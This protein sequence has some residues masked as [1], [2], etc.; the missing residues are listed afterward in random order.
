[1]KKQIIITFGDDNETDAPLY[2]MYSQQHNPQPCYLRFD[3]EA[4]VIA[5]SAQYSGEI[6]GGVPADAW[7]RTVLHFN[8]D[9]CT[10]R[11]AIEAL[12]EDEDLFDLLSEI[13]EGFSRSDSHYERGRYTPEAED[14]I[15]SV[16]IRLSERP[17]LD[18]VMVYEADEWIKS[19]N[20][21]SLEELIEAGSI[22]SMAEDWEPCDADIA[23]LGDVGEA[24]RGYLQGVIDETYDEDKTE[25]HQKAQSILQA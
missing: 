18:R 25:V 2:K 10:S 11:T 24:L 20:N 6:G 19:G 5:L 23:V 22:E 7:N 15:E 12:A 4:S 1:M 14:A 21:P 17:G 13:K 8:I 9:P 16:E 3:P